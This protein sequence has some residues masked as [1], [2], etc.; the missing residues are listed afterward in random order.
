[1]GEEDRPQDRLTRTMPG[2]ERGRRERAVAVGRPAGA[3]QPE[4]QGG[5][6]GISP[7]QGTS[8]RPEIRRNAPK[9]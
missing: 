3:A 2:A 7:L 5:H 8:W 9:P 4:P 1:M 6:G